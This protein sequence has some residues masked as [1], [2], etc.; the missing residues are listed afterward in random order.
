MTSY[1]ISDRAAKDCNYAFWR[2]DD[3]MCDVASSNCTVEEAILSPC[4]NHSGGEP[5]VKNPVQTFTLAGKV[6]Q[7]LLDL[8]DF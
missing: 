5:Q 2:I 8:T 4:W 6:Y 3:N 1:P 7:D